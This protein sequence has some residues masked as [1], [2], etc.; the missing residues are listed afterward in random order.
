MIQANELRIGNLTQQGEVKNFFESGVHVGYGKTYNFNELEPITLT[1]EWL[2]KC[3]ADFKKK[4]NHNECDIQNICFEFNE[5][6]NLIYTAGEGV[7]LSEPIE[8]VHQ[9]QNLYFALTGEELQ[10]K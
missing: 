6:L 9:L 1:E 2:L 8:F 5:N 3:G 7:K 10:I 4:S